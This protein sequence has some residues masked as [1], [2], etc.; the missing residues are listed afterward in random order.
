MIYP[1]L[2]QDQ[3]ILAAIGKIALRHGQLDYQLRMVV[4]T[5]ANVTIAEARDATALQG[6]SE[7]R[8]RVRRHARRRLGESEA[9]VRLDALLERSRRASDRRNEL[10]HGLWAQE[11]DGRPLIQNKYQYF[12]PIPTLDNLEDLATEL[13]NVAQALVESCLVGGFVHRALNADS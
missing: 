10:L 9:M 5:L 3:R 2:P 4:R 11:L 1:G 6:S 13:F 12:E 8:R 7:L